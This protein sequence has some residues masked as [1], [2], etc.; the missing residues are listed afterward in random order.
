MILDDTRAGWEHWPCQSCSLEPSPWSV[1][2]VNAG[3]QQWWYS[4]KSRVASIKSLWYHFV[5]KSHFWTRGV[6]CNWTIE[7]G[8]HENVYSS[9]LASLEAVIVGHLSTF[10]PSQDS[11]WIVAALSHFHLHQKVAL[12]FRSFSYSTSWGYVLP[13]RCQWVELVRVP[14]TS[15]LEMNV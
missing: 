6:F 9:Y 15:R 12:V 8:A 10:S 13:F 3:C 1:D 7:V 2:Q 5:T 14:L 4:K 11:H